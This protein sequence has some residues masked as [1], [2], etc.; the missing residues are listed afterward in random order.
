MPSP[1]QNEHWMIWELYRRRTWSLKSPKSHSSTLIWTE[2]DNKLGGGGE[3]GRETVD[4]HHKFPSYCAAFHCQAKWSGW[5][6]WRSAQSVPGT[7]QNTTASSS[8]IYKYSQH[9]GPASNGRRWPLPVWS[10]LLSFAPRALCIPFLTYIFQNPWALL[11]A[12]SLL[13]PP[14]MY[15]SPHH[16]TGCFLSVDTDHSVIP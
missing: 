6:P 10:G 11:A 8:I 16:I 9:K 5:L 12:H 2:G 1:K 15:L 7:P 4:W 13:P 3:R 14:A